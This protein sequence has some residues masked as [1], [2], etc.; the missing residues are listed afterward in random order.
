MVALTTAS[1]LAAVCISAQDPGSFESRAEFL[2]RKMDAGL[3]PTS[4]MIAM[5]KDPFPETRIL[6]IRAVASSSD[7]SQHDLLWE[8]L[9]D[10]DFR[11]RY[12]V[13][14]AAGRL[15]VHGRDL[16]FR[17]LSDGIPKVRQAAAWAMTHGGAESFGPFMEVLEK[18]PDM[19]VQATAMANL[20]RFDDAGWESTA[21]AAATSPEVQLRRAAAYS[22]ARS[23]RPAARAT[24]RRL[25]ADPVAVIRLSAMTGLG[26]A[27]LSKEDI[28]ILS[29]AVADDDPRVRAAACG[30]LAAQALPPVSDAVA[31]SI[32]T[33]WTTTEP[34]VA[35]MA[36]R[37]AG[38]R[39]EIGSGAGLVEIAKNEEPW[40][41]SE[42]FAAAAHRG[43]EGVD[44]LAR[45]WLSG[46]ELWKRRAVAMVAP[47]L[48]KEIEAMVVVAD[49]AEV[50][51]A[52]LERLDGDEVRTRLET[53]ARLVAEDPDPA[54]R[55]A[56]LN[57]LAD[58][59]AAGGFQDLLD[60]ARGWRSDE[61]PDARAAALTAALAAAEDSDQREVVVRRAA[62]DTDPAVAVLVIDAARSMGLPARSQERELRHNAQWYVDLVEWM[63]EHHWLDVVTDRGTIRIRLE[64]LEAPISSRE[65]YELA[66]VGFYDGLTFH[67]VVPNF[68]VQGGD[69]RG[70]GWGGAGFI[71]PDEPA[72]RPYDTGRVGIATSGPNTG[73][74]Q[75]FFT[76]APADH[77]VGHYT[78][79]GE[80]VHG[81][82]ILTRIRVGDRIRRI[83]VASGDEPPLPS[84]VLLGQIEW[85]QLET[86]EGWLEEYQ[87]A[88][89]DQQ[90]ID[91]L[92]EALGSY[93]IVT[94]LGS[95]CHDSEREVPRL[96]RVLDEMDSPLFEHQMIGVDRMRRIDDAELAIKAGVERTVD[97]VATFV[98]FDADGNELGRVVETAERPI[99]KLLVEFITPVEGW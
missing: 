97:R 59:G 25:A 10:R 91:R 22:L 60:L 90:A 56:A 84:L 77:L 47:A 45:G 17:G 9:R 24:L 86:I 89:P 2:L 44:E 58:A 21:A 96:V 5:L 55:T 50:R 85:S 19:G 41:A 83:E 3:L 67:R 39:P 33:M 20:W 65:I 66:S 68:V 11:V 16:A 51:L 87:D 37:A 94:V 76:L 61:M 35:I 26:R 38:A 15:G 52:W 54:V 95:W 7:P 75:F 13:M 74:S 92:G 53:L 93:R 34:H 6:V 4:M 31:S 88:Q 63:Q 43:A 32:V 49:D 62:A 81:R 98:V 40:L 8:Y 78:N 71:L 80:V 57:H 72:F 42:A 29:N 18:E 70:D 28:V 48:G 64:S 14:I 82:E 27:P 36:A 73:S 1:V 69:P 23:P 12:E 99:E 46:D 30:A 79:F